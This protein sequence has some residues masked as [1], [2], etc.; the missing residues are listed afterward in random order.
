MYQKWLTLK[1]II[2]QQTKELHEVEAAIWLE[3][4]K[5]GNLNLLGGKTFDAD[6]F[7]VTITHSESIKVDQK[8]AAL[9]PDLF[10]VKYEFDKTGY[11]QLVKTQKDVVDECITITK[12]KPSFRIV[13]LEN[14]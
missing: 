2:I 9:R 3:A 14:E 7:K 6:N 1:E 11:R 5:N 12:A 4:E 13:R 10:K 8:A